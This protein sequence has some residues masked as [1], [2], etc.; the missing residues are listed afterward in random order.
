MTPYGLYP[1]SM[2]GEY[3]KEYPKPKGN[4]GAVWTSIRT[5]QGFEK[6]RKSHSCVFGRIIV[7]FSLHD[8]SN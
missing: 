3:L 2:K 1:I 4:L 5:Y 8:E 7:A 6:L